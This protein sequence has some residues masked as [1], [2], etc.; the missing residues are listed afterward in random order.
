MPNQHPINKQVLFT[1]CKNILLQHI[2]AGEKAMQEAQEAANSEE[3]S[4]MG[5]KYE[6][7]RAMSQLARDMNASQV[8]KNKEELTSLLKLENIPVGKQI[9]IG[10][11]VYCDSKLFY[12]SVALGQVIID[13]QTIT[14]ISSKAPLAKAMLGKGVGESFAFNNNTYIIKHIA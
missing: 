14:V 12:V 3:K 2:A 10:S 6:T 9:I 7:G 5:D 13:G 11:L 4:S 8:V 1:H